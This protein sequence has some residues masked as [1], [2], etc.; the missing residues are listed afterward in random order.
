VRPERLERH[1]H[2]LVRAAQLAHPHVNRVLAALEA[3][4]VLG[5]GAGA[6]ALVTATGGLAVARAMA[7][8]DALAVLAGAGG[9]REVVQ[10][11]AGLLPCARCRRRLGVLRRLVFGLVARGGA[12]QDFS[13]TTTRCRTLCTSP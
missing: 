1:R 13:S 10:A 7:A 6:V 11:D 4:A 3:G 12:H 5:A 2:F 9:R 8:A